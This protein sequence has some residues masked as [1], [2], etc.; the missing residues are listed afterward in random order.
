MA[1]RL[2]D[3]MEVQPILELVPDLNIVRDLRKRIR[4]VTPCDKF[5][6]FKRC[7]CVT[8]IFGSV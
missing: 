5:S 8:K 4:N 3:G 1:A 2:V 6:F 7:V